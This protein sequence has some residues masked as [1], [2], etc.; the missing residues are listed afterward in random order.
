M[1]DWL[2][3]E[4]QKEQDQLSGKKTK[5]RAKRKPKAKAAI[6]AN[7]PHGEKGDFVR[8]TIT[9]PPDVYE[10]LNMEVMKRKVA[11][12]SDPTISAILREAAVA[13]LK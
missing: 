2:A 7:P 10:L 1:S 3:D 5:A 9:M 11:K 8:M 6:E 12:Q 4:T 13:Y